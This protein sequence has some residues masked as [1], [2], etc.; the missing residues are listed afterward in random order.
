MHSM[1]P[2]IT[3]EERKRSLGWFAVWWIETFTL[4]GRGGAVGQTIRFAPEVFQFIVNCYALKKNGRRRFSRVTLCR[5]KGWN[6]SGIAA[7]IALFEALAPC[8]FDHWA[9]AGETYTFLG[10]TYYFDEGEP[11]GRPIQNPVIHILATREDQP[12]ALDTPVFTTKGWKTVG[13]I[14]VGDYVI[15]SNGLPV[16]VKRTTKVFH[17]LDCYEITFGDGEKIV[18]SGSHMWTVERRDLHS[19]KHNTVTLTTEEISKTFY[20]SYRGARYRIPVTP[21]VVLPKKKYTVDPYY[22]GLWLGDGKYGSACIAYDVQ[23]EDEVRDILT[24]LLE[25]GESLSFYEHV[26]RCGVVNIVRERAHYNGV[27]SLRMRLR[28]LNLLKNKHIPEEYFMGSVE[29][30]LALLQGL[31]DADGG[32][33]KNKGRA[34]F[35]NTNRNLID[36]VER[37]LI[38]LGYK[39]SEVAT[40]TGAWRVSFQP[41]MDM[42]P[43][44]LPRKIERVKNAKNHDLSKYRTIRDVRKVDTVPVKCIGIDNADHLF[45]AGKHMILTHN[46]GNTYES[47]YYNCTSPDAPLSV[48]KGMGLDPALARI[49]LP[50]GGIIEP[51]T[52]GAKGSDGGIET[53]V[54]ADETHLYDKPRLRDM[55]DTVTRN[56]PKRAL[57]ADPWLLETTT[58]F[59]AGADSVAERSFQ[60]AEDIR[61]GRIKHFASLYFDWRYSV[62]PPTEWGDEKKLKRA[63]IEAYGSA[64]KSDDGKDYIF[65]PDGR[66]EAVSPETGRTPEG[67]S[68]QDPN[69]EPACSA[70]GWV[71]PEEMMSNMYQPSADPAKSTRY[72]LNS[73]ASAED[74][75]L[76]E[77]QLVSH[78]VMSDLVNSAIAENRLPGL[79]KDIIST[80]DEITL[81]FD[82]SVSNDSTALVGCRVRDG[83]LFV[84]KLDEAPDTA[85]R[86]DWRVDRDAFDDQVRSMFENYNVIGCFADPAFFESNIRDWERDYGKEMKVF[87]QGKNSELIMRWYTNLRHNDMYKALE[88]IHT[89][90]SYELSDV[91]N[92]S[93]AIRFLADPRLLNH[94]RHAHKRARNYGYLIFKETPKSPKKIDAAMAAILAYTAR[95]KYLGL[96]DEGKDKSNFFIPVVGY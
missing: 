20:S 66:M 12:L 29:Q 49:L 50:E 7:A 68:L 38:S 39:Y 73:R 3:S 19:G 47:I 21:P 96:A 70:D 65:L 22:L 89:N 10:Q 28:K 90:A 34:T 56:L 95:Q 17:D 27:D 13:D 83:L 74:A 72:Y 85:Q 8:R 92:D 93:G 1:I 41:R 35:T 45:A 80:T 5:P 71:I 44:R 11:V 2:M 4:I 87:A 79:W 81:G 40:T 54:I 78:S 67:W 91:D 88:A 30:R 59:Q 86:A 64:A 52:T 18:S 60:Y 55:F 42:I 82:G 48:L 51:I 94:I 16:E 6:K 57:D 62:L 76:T 84:I 14:S 31:M 36:G 23:D 24:N 75:W 63:V 69:C 46:T 25:E 43:F 53:F 15:G 33:E 9:E 61:Q 26:G 77:D 37:L 58:Y 32:C